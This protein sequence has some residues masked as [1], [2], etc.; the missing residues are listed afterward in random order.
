MINEFIQLAEA[1]QSADLKEDKLLPLPKGDAYRVWLTGEGKVS[2]IDH[3]SDKERQ[4]LK[5]YA[6]N[7]KYSFPAFNQIIV[8]SGDEAHTKEYKKAIEGI[9][10]NM[11]EFLTKKDLILWKVKSQVGE[12]ETLGQVF[13]AFCAIKNGNDF[14]EDLVKCFGGKGFKVT[15]SKAVSLFFDVVDYIDYPMSHAHTLDRLNEV[16]LE[17]DKGESLHDGVDA[18]GLECV[19][20]EKLMD[21]LP[22]PYFGGL[23]LRSSNKDVR[24]FKRYHLTESE[25]F[26]IGQKARAKAAIA[27]RWVFNQDNEDSTYG[28]VSSD[29][30]LVAYPVN[31]AMRR[32][33]PLIQ[34]FGGNNDPKQERLVFSAAAKTVIDLLKGEGQDLPNREL[35]IFSIR[36]MDKARTK[37]VYYRNID[38]SSLAHASDAWNEGCHNLPPLDVKERSKDIR[39]GRKSDTDRKTVSVVIET[40]FPARLYQYLNKYY[41]RNFATEDIKLSRFEPST[42]MELML[43]NEY[44][45]APFAQSVLSQVIIQAGNYYRELCFCVGRDNDSLAKDK[46]IYLGIL[47][48]LLYKIGE[49]KE[50]YMKETAFLLGK[51]LRIADGLHKCYCESVRKGQYAGEFCGSSMLSA[52]MENPT[53][54][55]AQLGQRSA[56]Y[57]KWAQSYQKEN[58]RLVHWWL[59]Q[60]QPI[61]EALHAEKLPTRLSDAERAEVFLGYLASLPKKEDAQTEVKDFETTKTE[62]EKENN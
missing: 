50:N 11:I 1:L 27:F 25:S 33:L 17:C 57:V 42:G 58:A 2:D 9:R 32:R 53:S 56:P 39:R 19:G 24:T 8:S 54:A 38:I 49:R 61:A 34:M 48:L 55:L 51:F 7:N 4:S 44:E 15:P 6:P 26:P 59:N 21:K 52:M 47:G 23:R 41:K 16:L 60:W 36:K 5:K 43:M 3:L 35:R 62:L 22:V 30:I 31:M 37:V 10:R 13:K 18:F 12:G 20:V 40:V 28:K 46:G 29:E 45:V 14:L